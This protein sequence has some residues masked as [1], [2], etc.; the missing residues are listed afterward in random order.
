MTEPVGRHVFLVAHGLYPISGHTVTG[1]GVRAW[2]LLQGLRHFGH[3]ITYATPEDTAWPGWEKGK[4][5]D[6]D[7][8]LFR[9]ASDLGQA[10]RAGSPDVLVIVNWELIEWLPTDLHIPI[11]FDLIAPRLLEMQFQETGHQ[12]LGAEVLRYL[13]A[14]ARGSRFL[15]STER[16]KAFYYSWLMMSG[17]D[18]REEL[19]DVIP[20][21]AAPSSAPQSG[22]RG[23]ELTFVCGGVSW[24]WQDPSPCLNRLLQ[25]LEERKQ[26]QLLVMAGGY[27]LAAQK[28]S[29]THLS[30][31]LSA[32]SRLAKKGLL[33]Y[34][35]MEKLFRSADVA[36]DLGKRTP[37][38]EL[39]FSYRVVEYLRCG[40]PVI[41]NH[42]LDI[43]AKID[44][45][46]AGW[47]IDTEEN[48]TAFKDLIHEILSQPEVV[49][50]RSQNALRLIREQLNW[51]KTIEPLARF[52]ENP[53]PV[54]R[55]EHLFS[56]LLTRSRNF[57]EGLTRQQEEFKHVEEG[58]TRQQEEFKH[59]S[60][61]MQRIEGASKAY[62]Q[63]LT[64]HLQAVESASQ[65]RFE[66]LT[67][68]VHRAESGSR[69][70][71]HRLQELANAQ[72][73]IEYRVLHLGIR[74]ILRGLLRI[75]ERIFRILI[76]PLFS[77]WNTKNIAIITRADLFPPYHGAA[78]RILEISRAL[79]HQC[80]KVFL[81]TADRTTYLVFEKGTM[82]EV[83]Y[84]KLLHSFPFGTTSLAK[85]LRRK[86]VPAV[87]CFL[88]FPLYDI[89]HWVRTLFVAYQH[90]I[91][92]YQAEFPG[93]LR[94]ALFAR[95]FFGGK[96][97]LV[98]HNIEFSR[99]ADELSPRGYR[100]LRR[101]E[102]RL[103]NRADFV[104]TMS[105]VDRDILQAA[106]VEDDKITTI[107]HGVDLGRFR[108]ADPRPLRKKY[109]LDSE[110]PIL[111]Y[112]G[113][114]SYAPNL[115]AAKALG[116]IILP[117]LEKRGYRVVCLAIGQDPPLES[118]HPALRFLGAVDDIASHLELCDIAVVPLTSGGGTRMKLL[119]YFAARVPVVCTKKAAEG[120]PL[121]A[122]VHA[123]LVNRVDE[124]VEPI[125]E[126]IKESSRARELADR[127]YA[128]VQEYD[129]SSIAKRHMQL[130]QLPWWR[131]E[132]T[133]LKKAR[134]GG[135]AR[136][137]SASPNR[138]PSVATSQDGRSIS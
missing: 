70:A 58:L 23:T 82:H 12:G 53:K 126:L 103:C 109:Q 77:R 17:L 47:I 119:E 15:C 22:N 121:K 107:P 61:G 75:P 43:A 63:S 92:L 29:Q 86:G 7:V 88:W 110:S 19:I 65:K 49:S 38:R 28:D 136:H 16:Q 21:S 62:F 11:V 67:E 8:V 128:L 102:T 91:S 51:E 2:G 123:I 87:D 85:Y 104:I 46:E 79:S 117:A 135:S 115:Q 27:P 96:T 59:V 99:I 111:V 71:Q 34:D 106:G 95:W 113:I 30:R 64:E 131:T 3:R 76:K 52:C 100:F 32:S 25:V 26:G 94:P 83:R 4:A 69:E 137:D 41:C 90:G 68:S 125:I 42:Y 31:E 114:Y 50:E 14:L 48:D 57:E 127:A 24:L 72:E 134:Q 10:I 138:E 60:E 81:I 20:I 84:P 98:E 105:D 9:T 74:G 13:N 44:A 124:M 101:A 54:I 6:I 132:E 120:L 97:A 1:N 89:N 55:R 66:S 39:S 18:C 56:T 93:Y 108:K 40:L 45:Y 37:E 116:R 130:Y 80:E 78:V 5:Q 122:G 112:H 129:W 73:R 35:E 118:L 133:S 33:S 36:V